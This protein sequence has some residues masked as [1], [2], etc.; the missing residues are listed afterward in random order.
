[1]FKLEGNRKVIVLV[2]TFIFAGVMA[3]FS[4]LDENMVTLLTTV[5]G[6]FFGSNVAEHVTKIARSGKKAGE[7]VKEIV[8]E[9]I[10]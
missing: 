7:E 1:M 10:D 3:F 8:N 4:K 6:L 5:S 9:K 2:V